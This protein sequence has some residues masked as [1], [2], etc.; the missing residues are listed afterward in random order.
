ML[1]SF[2]GAQLFGESY[3]SGTPRV[4][5]LHGWR[6]DHGDFVGVLGG[7]NPLPSIALDLPGFGAAPAPELAWGSPEYAQALLPLLDEME[8]P[9]VVVAHSFGGRVA[10]HLAAIAPERVG[11][12]VLTGVPLFPAVEGRRRSP[13]KFRLVKRLAGMGM[14]SP[15]R[16]ERERQRY[17]SADYRAASG[18]MRD[19]FVRL[20]A[21]DY[22]E[23][24]SQVS[25]PVELV[26]G[27]NDTE[28]PLAVARKTQEALP[29]NAPLTVCKG[30]GHMTPLTA[31]G[32]LRA[33]AE[34]LL[35]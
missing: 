19:I 22:R 25:C 2:A 8:R 7:Q 31:P 26:W 13:L 6:R 11:G 1:T 16:L 10:V 14:I 33:A 3:G 32:E 24:L 27:D 29:R 9:V 20:V 17:G 34:R 18:V 12:L 28:V 4:L 35:R 23:A 5:A 15:D 21:E 30:A